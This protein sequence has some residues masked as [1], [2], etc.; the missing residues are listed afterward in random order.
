VTELELRTA[1]GVTTFDRADGDKALT[2]TELTIDVGPEVA[3]V[4]FQTPSTIEPVENALVASWSAV[5]PSDQA[6]PV[7]IAT[8]IEGLPEGC[9]VAGLVRWED[10]QRQIAEGG[11]QSLA[12]EVLLPG[13][14]GRT[15]QIRA[16]VPARCAGEH[17]LS[18]CSSAPTASSRRSGCRSRFADRSVY[19]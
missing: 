1:N 9:D 6:V 4:T 17:T 12:S 14:D 8:T 15:G 13:T 5:S 16:D 19:A 7:W 2:D 3:K 10:L 11:W 18:S